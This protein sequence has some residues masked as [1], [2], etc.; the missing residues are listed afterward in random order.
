MTAAMSGP[1]LH[2]QA[3]YS[4][5]IHLHINANSSRCSGAEPVRIAARQMGTTHEPAPFLLVLGG[6]T[7]TVIRGLRIRQK[8]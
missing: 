7:C 3:K 6:K 4:Q 5:E 2:I 8:R 1:F